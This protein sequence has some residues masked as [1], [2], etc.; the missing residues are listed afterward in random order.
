MRHF[1]GNIPSTLAGVRAHNLVIEAL[2]ERLGLPLAHVAEAIPHDAEHFGDICHLTDAGNEILGRI[3][4]A[5]VQVGQDQD[6]KSAQDPKGA[7]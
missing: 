1:W 5:A 2:A 3:V 6:A 4:A 7:P